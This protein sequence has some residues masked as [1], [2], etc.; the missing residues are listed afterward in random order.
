M[1][2]VFHVG[3]FLLVSWPSSLAA[4]TTDPI[5]V[6]APGDGEY[7]ASFLKT[8]ASVLVL[9]RDLLEAHGGGVSKLLTR[10]ASV[11]ENYA[12]LGYYEAFTVRGFVL[13]HASGYKRDGLALVNEASAPLE[14]MERVEI[15]KGVTGVALGLAAP[16]GVVNY[17]V[18]RPPALPLRRL[19]LEYGEGASRRA[20][21]D[22]GGRRGRFGWRL[23]AAREE[24]RPYVKEAV[25]KRDFAGAAF[26]WRFDEGPVLSLDGDW[27]RKSQF[28]VPGYQAFGG[29]ALPAHVSPRTMLNRQAWS[30]PVTIESSNLGARLVWG[31]ADAWHAQ[32]AVVRSL[33]RAEDKAA[34]PYG[35]SSGPAYSTSFC[36]NGDYDLY[37]YRSSGEVRESVDGRVTL[38]GR[39]Q[40][41]AIKH[42]VLLGLQRLRRTV[43]L[44]REVFDF[45]GTDNLYRH[46]P[47][48]FAPSAL[49]TGDVHLVQ[50]LS[51]HA[52]FAQD[53]VAV[54]PR[55]TVHAGLR[56]SSVSDARFSK[57]DGSPTARWR[58]TLGAP[59]AALQ[60]SPSDGT[61][62]YAAYMQGLE[63]GG[64]AGTTAANAG[65][66]LDP[67][68][69]RQ[70]EA[71]V[72]RA[73]G[74]LLA[75]AAAFHIWKA[76]EFTDPGNALV[77]RGVARHS[78]LELTAAGRATDR[79]RVQT[80]A[81]FLRARI[82][83]TG[84]P[85]FDGRAPMNVPWLTGKAGLDWD[86][87]W[88]DGAG[89]EGVWT[90]VSERYARRDNALSV[91]GYQRVDVGLRYRR[92]AGALAWTWR[93]R[94]E[95]VFDARYWRDVGEYLGDGY[96]HLG[97]PRLLRA[98][99]Q[100]DI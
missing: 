4:Q 74:R 93:L 6:T 62:L 97:A 46:A 82:E 29:V 70:L 39:V 2:L 12:P 76:H 56:L 91:P 47:R 33:A 60:F 42:T 50:D 7:G 95:N 53:A 17:I 48:D 58:R 37:D 25:G 57:A 21:A 8:P 43:R 18:K 83:G 22:L 92:S 41:G 23:N 99:M 54:S 16:G 14:N 73:D 67:K 94:V 77:Q 89:L 5:I 68:T 13:D 52:V 24:L 88:L 69:T 66:I 98:S 79:L 26:D 51:E 64:T 32:G 36:G 96:L 20:H 80:G 40:T 71:G 65:R 31:D 30:A 72:K 44:G 9:S 78:G 19:L 34:F 1:Q 49:G 63:P 85:A 11:Q 38:S 75:S 100:I 27:Q 35:C 81:T 3:V 59:Q 84:V 45:V 10:D 28:S 90:Y 55:W 61:S 86:A 15:S 87:R